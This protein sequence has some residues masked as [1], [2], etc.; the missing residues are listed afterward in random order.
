MAGDGLRRRLVVAKNPP[1][2][3][4]YS[5][6]AALCLAAPVAI[7]WA[8]GDTTAGLTAAIGGF[9][10][11][12]GSNRPYV[13][14]AV[15]LAVIAMGFA[16]AVALGDWAAGVPWLGVLA[17]SVIATVATLLCNALVVGPPAAYMF[18]IAC[19]A[20]TAAASA[21]VPSWRIGLLVLSGGA[22][23]WI[24]HMAGALRGLRRPEKAVVSA[25]A[26]AVR[27]YCDAIGTSEEGSARHLAAQALHRSWV[28]LV[29]YQPAGVPP[30]PTLQRLRAVNRDLHRIFADAMA[31]SAANR[32]V[33][34]A[35]GHRISRLAETNRLAPRA[36]IEGLPLGRPSPLM[37]IREA[38]RPQSSHLVV[39]TRV[40]IAVLIAGGVASLLGIDRSYWAMAAAVLVLHQGFDRRR[41]LRRG[42]ERSVGTWLGLVLA[43]VLLVI[44]PQGLWLAGILAVLQFTIE[45]VVIPVYAVA[46]VFITPAALL[47]AAGGHRVGD[48]A[49][50]LLARGVDTL[51]GAVVAIGV[52]LATARRH[53]AVKLSEAV[54]QTLDS[55]AA[56]APHLA[57]AAVNT[58]DALAARRDLQLR[59]FE[60]Q[61]AYQA[62]DAGSRTLR[63]TAEELWPAVAATEDFAYRTLAMCWVCE[64]QSTGETPWPQTELERFQRVT[65]DLAAAIRTG[66]HPQDLGPMPV[67]GA[68]ELAMVRDCLHPVND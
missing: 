24:V 52:Y 65:A 25:A 42:I 46:V 10:A 27:R 35:S 13:S 20:G 45:M 5:A 8:L 36:R 63:N 61:Q 30:G 43:G 16:A 68:T 53:D 18:V 66:A 7:G 12:Y 19:A 38:L 23:A 47:I 21:P 15:H 28:T 31:A 49:E 32:P 54:A 51:I 22:F 2:R 59:A 50:L 29:N 17:V 40:G 6:R 37:L 9:T 41:T 56:V 58:P 55:L 4:W 60:L 33:D 48:V 1:G 67:H 64:R 14:R 11:L 39:A 57:A 34:T 44:N 62:A 3:W 26:D